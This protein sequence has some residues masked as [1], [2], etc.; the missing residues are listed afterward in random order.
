[1]NTPRIVVSLGTDVHSFDR[2]LVWAEGLAQSLPD[3]GVMIQHGASRAPKPPA[4]GVQ[5]TTREQ[6]LSWYATADVVVT[7]GG[8]GSI[9][10]AREAGAI[11]LVVPRDPEL[12]EHV[13]GHQLAFVPVM[14][15]AGHAVMVTDHDRFVRLV[16]ERLA[17]P[18][19]GKT[20][21]RVPQPEP[22]VEEFARLIDDA[23]G[24][25]LSL[26]TMLRR[27]RVL[28]PGSLKTH[29][30]APARP[31]NLEGTS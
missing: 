24:Q 9:L 21:P 18:S 30:S 15:Q 23:A 27:S 6:L 5:G 20:E 13:D 26:R 3:V 11:P 19:I 22:A 10:D 17:D 12:G 29:H 4:H 25:P 7:Q 14:E 1:M 31:A 28:L 2:L 16:A 8:P